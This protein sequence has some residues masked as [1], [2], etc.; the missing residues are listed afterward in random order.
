MDRI[1][2][3]GAGLAGL[4][5]AE[6]LRRDGF[7]GD[8]ILLGD[9]SHPP[10]DRPPLSKQ[11][12]S[13]KWDMDKVWLRIE[14][15][16]DADLRLGV[17]AVALDVAAR[18]LTLADGGTLAYDG[19]VLAT[20][21]SPRTLPGFEDAL[22]LRTLDDSR[23][24][25]ASLTP[26]AKVTV[27]GAGFI[28]S[29]VA[30]TA[31]ELGCDVTIV[32]VLPRPLARVFPEPI[33]DALAAIHAE[34]GV[35]LRFGDSVTSAAA[36]DA[37]IVVVGIGVT[38]NTA[39]LEASGLTLDNGVVC[40]ETCRALGGDDRVVAAGDIARWP[41]ALF[42]GELMR[43]EHWTN[44]AEQAEVAAHSLLGAREPF[45][46]VPYF[47]SDQYDVKIQ[48]VGV[49]APTDDFEVFEGSIAD[50]KFVAGFGRDGRLVGALAFSMPRQLMR[51]RA[52]IAERSAF[53]RQ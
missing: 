45:A 33:G 46:P 43:V 41:N 49:A 16:F 5:A 28:G 40:D 4:R 20:G 6:T 31:A 18:A 35:T 22:L 36:L 27:I 1:V 51:Y 23:R 37:D 10:Y 25:Q 38:P 30:S 34:Q 14:D 21:A 15:G 42:D 11:Y 52:L 9:E 19:L 47:W 26:G 17:A 12:L 8:L 29:E 32:E 44:A 3:V 39:W 2:V 48:F 50:R 13:G 24:L 53:S 7:T